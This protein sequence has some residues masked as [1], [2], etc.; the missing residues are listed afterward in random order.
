[1][2]DSAPG[3]LRYLSI[4]WEGVNVAAKHDGSSFSMCLSTVA[5]LF[6]FLAGGGSVEAVA[7][8]DSADSRSVAESL[9]SS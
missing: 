5:K 2:S 6:R 1:M 7:S 9:R 4:T 8:T 3:K